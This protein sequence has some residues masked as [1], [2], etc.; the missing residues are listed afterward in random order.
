M[1]AG[2]SPGMSDIA[3]IAGVS[4]N[5]VSLALRDSPLISDKTKRR[6]VKAA[7]SVG[8]E[9]NAAFS[10]FMSEIKM[11]G[12]RRYRETVA[13]INANEDP[14][15]LKSHPT[16]PKYVEGIRRAAE[17]EGFALDEFWLHDPA[18]GARALARILRMR[19]IRGGVITGLMDNNR[20]PA[21]FRELWRSFKFVITGV[22]TYEPTLNF[23]IADHFL[24]AYQAALQ[25]LAHGYDRPALVLDREIDELIEGRFTGGFLRAQINMPLQNRIEPFFK[26]REAHENPAIFARWFEKNRPNAL[27]CLYN[28]AKKWVEDMGLSVPEDVALIQL[29]R[30]DS[31]PEWAGLNQRNDLAGEAA[32]E[33]L[34]QLLY[35]PPGAD[36]GTVTATLVSPEWV[37]S[38]TICMRGGNTKSGPSGRAKPARPKRA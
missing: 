27:V 8:Y 28:S 5:T 12:L 14:D 15:A 38:S 20:L 31:E 19:G 3:K 4:K 34:A 16:I 26:V 37:E 35:S 25:A 17:R 36:S 24:I 10:K 6:V 22:R 1:G 2:K 7:Q 13:L 23:A 21:K 9:K 30:R 29:E 33:R 18:M 11:S 32:V